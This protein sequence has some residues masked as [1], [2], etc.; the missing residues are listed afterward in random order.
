MRSDGEGK[1]GFN[2]LVVN[3]NILSKNTLRFITGAIIALIVSCAVYAGGFLLM[4]LVMYIVWAGSKEYVNILKNKG[5]MPF[6]RL[7]IA[8]DFCFVILTTLKIFDLVPVVLTM[9]TIVSFM[10]VLF[11]GRQPYIAN[12]AT[13][14]LGFLYGGW[15]PC[16]LILIRQIGMD[17]SLGLITI[18]SNQGLGFIFLLFFTILFTDV[19]A[20]FFGSRFGKRPLAPIISPKKTIEGAIG[21][22]I[23]GI[24]VA[25]GIGFF[26]K[27]AWY[28]ALVVGILITIFAQI[29][30]LAESLIKRDAG[31]KDSGN[32]LPGHGG[33]MD[34][35]DS[36]LFSTPVAYF[37][38]NHFVVSNHLIHQIMDF[39]KKAAHIIGI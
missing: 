33:F 22:S 34:R 24:L 9:G 2:S 21:G 35:A 19:G 39:A 8:V 13:T 6:F 23:C 18:H 37:Y 25:L 10:A 31:V 11:Y 30:D 5:F 27:I 12:V 32:S 4:L 1:R 17:D 36:Y 29:G 7:I 15:L 14:V 20:Y 28:H 3:L 38:F 16:Y 26:L